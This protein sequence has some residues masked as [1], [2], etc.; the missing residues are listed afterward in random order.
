MR[1]HEHWHIENR[2][3]VCGAQLSCEFRKTEPDGVVIGE[4]DIDR[5]DEIERDNEEPKEWTHPHREKG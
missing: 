1:D 4:E 3:R 5:S 2:N